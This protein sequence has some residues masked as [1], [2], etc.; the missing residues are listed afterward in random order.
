MN[1]LRGEIHHQA[2]REPEQ[3]RYYEK[4]KVREKDRKRGIAM[5]GVEKSHI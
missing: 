5:E 3:K 1:G 2:Q 4:L